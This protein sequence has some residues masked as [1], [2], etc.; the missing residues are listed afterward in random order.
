MF[1]GPGPM[2]GGPKAGAVAHASEREDEM[3]CWMRQRLLACGIA[4]ALATAAGPG[5]AAEVEFGW[6]GTVT[7]V[8]PTLAAAL[9]PGSGI[10]VGADI[11]VNYVFEST[12]SDGNSDPTVGEYPGALLNWNVYIGNYW[13]RH[14]ASG[15]TNIIGILLLNDPYGGD[16][17][18]YEP[19]DS[20]ISRP[21]LPGLPTLESDVFFLHYTSDKLPNDNL[22]LTPLVPSSWDQAYGG[23]FDAS[24]PTKVIDFDLVAVCTGSCQPAQPVPL[25][26]GAALSGTLLLS[27]AG[28]LCSRRRARQRS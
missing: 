25:G 17:T 5:R 20:V 23:I 14:D 27:G 24:G 4:L 19:V 15:S 2:Y 7:A 13:F 10:E 18:V 3:M 9:P 12:T 26:A 22:P 11:W 21:P 6:T 16:V 28:Y 1:T 8:D